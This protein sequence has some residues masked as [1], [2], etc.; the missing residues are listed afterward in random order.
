MLS[1]YVLIGYIFDN[2]KN[3]DFLILIV[4]FFNWIKNIYFLALSKN[5]SSVTGKI[6]NLKVTKAKLEMND[7]SHKVAH[8]LSFSD[9][10]L[11]FWNCQKTYLLM[12]ALLEIYCSM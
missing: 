1:A 5:A 8:S 10:K 4:F 7:F 3:N 2:R 9:Y 11:I 12:K 6:K